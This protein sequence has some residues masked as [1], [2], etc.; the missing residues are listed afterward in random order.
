MEA[1]FTTSCRRG[2][3][4]LR[5]ARTTPVTSKATFLDAGGKTLGTAAQLGPATW[6]DR[7]GVTG[8][9]ER[10]ADG[11]VPA[12][13]RVIQVSMTFTSAKSPN[14]G[15]HAYVDSISFAMSSGGTV[16]ITDNGIVNAA[17][18]D[19]GP[20]AAGEMIMVYTTGINL[21]SSSRSQL[22]AAGKLT[23]TLGNV[24][25]FFDGTQA[26]ML[27]VTSGQMAGVVPFDV[28]TKGNVQVRVEYQGVASQT[29]SVPVVKTSP[30]IFTQDGTLNGVGLIYN[31]DY[32]LNSR[33]NPAAEGS[34]VAIYW[35]GAGQSD[36]GG[37]DG[38]IETMVLSRPRA[39]IGVSIG[40]QAA[41]LIYAGAVP[42]AW[43]GLLMAEVRVPSGLS[44]GDPVSV[45]VV[46]TAGTA[47]SPDDRVMVWVKKP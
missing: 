11:D 42:Y 35:T 15:V 46:I 26:P 25:I 38:R 47:S 33:D 24:R 7:S 16:S 19:P 43:S 45:P 14:F 22:D 41:E 13:T 36:P 20:V 40:S 32:S 12:G 28:D 1:V 31:A 39:A 3:A 8:L 10:S 21:A 4:A 18:G 37:T 34:P 23:T 29:V 27:S 9:F 30:G 17:T 6:K 2:W 44:S 5:M